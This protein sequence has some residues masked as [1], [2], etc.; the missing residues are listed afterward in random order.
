MD[1]NSFSLD[2]PPGH[3]KL[4][5]VKIEHVTKVSKSSI[6]VIRFHFEDYKN[7]RFFFLEKQSLLLCSKEKF[8]YKL[9]Y[10]LIFEKFFQQGNSIS[11]ENIF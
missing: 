11:N 8:E 6:S 2:E 3:K 4:K 7:K 1:K 9:I 5:N 10:N